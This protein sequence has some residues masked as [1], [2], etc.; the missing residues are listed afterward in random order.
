MANMETSR[1]TSD[2]DARG[3]EP[4]VC[5]AP[6]NGAAEKPTAKTNLWERIDPS[7]IE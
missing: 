7:E 5:D 4:R 3:S 2:A 1:Q 6:E